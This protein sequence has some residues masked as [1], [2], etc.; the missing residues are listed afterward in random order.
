MRFL[1][2]GL[3]FSSAFADP[4]SLFYIG[5]IVGTGY[6]K[7]EHTYVD[8]NAISIKD[9]ESNILFNAGIQAGYMQ[10]LASSL[11]VWGVDACYHFGGG[12]S[13][14]DLKNGLQQVQGK[15]TVK[16]PGIVGANA[17]IGL[18]L[19]PAFMIGGKIGYRYARIQAAY[20][21]LINEPATRQI[22]NPKAHGF[23]FGLSGYYF[24]TPHWLLNV[25]FSYSPYQNVKARRYEKPV[26]NLSKGFSIKQSPMAVALGLNYAF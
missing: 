10:Q 6:N 12:S 20:R 9:N 13:N 26:N 4:L 8:T 24:M 16:T 3:I 15:Y 23:S 21:D 2:L 22:Y 1:L 18:R 14:G 17:M 5:G 7:V 19:N 25:D 11:F